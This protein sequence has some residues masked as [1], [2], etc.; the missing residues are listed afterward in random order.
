MR[1]PEV[2]IF[3]IIVL[4]I[5]ISIASA[6]CQK[7]FP[8]GTYVNPVGKDM[9]MGDPFILFHEGRYYLYGTTSS[10]EGFK[11]WSSDNMRDWEYEGFAYHET[12]S[13]WGERNYWAPEVYFYNGDYLMVYSCLGKDTTNNRMLLCL[14]KSN[15]PTGPFKDVYAPWFDKGFSCIDA[16]IFFDDDH[17]IY[18]YFDKVGY[19]G[20]WPDGYMYGLIY[21]MK[22]DKELVPAGD[23]VFCSKA[24]QPWEHPLSMRSRC[25]EGSFI[26]KHDGIYYMTYSA[27]H[28]QD[29]YYGIG[30]ST[31]HS[32]FGPWIKSPGNPLIGMDEKKGI[33][34]PGHN[35]FTVSPDSSELFIVY[36]THV[37][38]ENTN[39][40]VNIDRAYFDELG[41]LRVIGP[42]RS[43]QTLPSGVKK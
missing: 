2:R 5:F 28:Y 43:P 35:C 9:Y 7:T 32:P 39:R 13:S 30:Y 20:N 24:D 11:S 41:R 40:R 1:L 4:I 12:D 36:H 8:E 18:L 3:S 38:K 22:L 42:T 29:P 25:N 15:S 17:Q 33:F 19:E 31:A 10:S 23:T 6:Q 27:N 21:C 37:S 34:G 26:L 14:A 16:H